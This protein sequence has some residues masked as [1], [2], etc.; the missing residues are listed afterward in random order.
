MS[1]LDGMDAFTE[2]LDRLS[3][4]EARATEL[5]ERLS[6]TDTTARQAKNDSD[7]SLRL[8]QEMD[9]RAKKGLPA[10]KELWEAADALRKYIGPGG[11]NAAQT[12]NGDDE[13][14]TRLSR[15]LTLANGY[16][17]QLPF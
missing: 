12:L 1:D 5:Q 17:D 10:L 14:V 13:H 7:R 8:A 4:A 3:R 11:I 2:V 16:C 6:A 9:D 15:A